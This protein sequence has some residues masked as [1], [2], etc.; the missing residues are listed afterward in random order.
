[1][2]WSF[3]IGSVRGTDIRI[4]A[5]F[6]LLLAWV[7]VAAWMAGGPAAAAVNVAFILALF[8]CVVLHELGHVTMARRFGVKT[9]DITLLPIG[10]LARLERIPEDPKQEIAVALAG[11]AVNV[12]IWAILTLALGAS[13]QLNVLASIEDPNQGFVQR[14]ATVNL[15][16]VLFNMIPAF[17]MDGGRVFRAVLALFTD[18][19]RATRIAAQTG[20][21]MAFLFGF[22]GLTGG[23]PLLLLIAVFIFFAAGA[24]SSDAAMRGRAQDARARDAMITSYEALAPDDTLDTAAQAV[25]RTTQAEFPVLGA[26]GRLAGILTRHSIIAAIEADKRADRV[27]AHMTDDIPAVRLT[28]PMEKVLTAMQKS[29]PGVAV[30]DKA[31]AFLGYITRENI[32][33]WFILSRK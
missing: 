29:P 24:E 28:T 10:G 23:N 31:G 8:A 16:L 19:V 30:T 14:L 6:F 21:A 13:V 1:M 22:L 7:L 26:D 2:H 27:S 11:P 25:L 12:V 20:Q 5:T 3:S 32:G 17:P 4:H 33:E 18:R 15:I 9:P